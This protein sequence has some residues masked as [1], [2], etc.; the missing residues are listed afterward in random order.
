VAA[1]V[2]LSWFLAVPWAGASIDPGEP[3]DN[4]VDLILDWNTHALTLS[5][6][7]A[8]ING[9]VIRSTAGIFTGALANNLGF[10]TEDTDTRISG[11]MGF[12]LTGE[13]LLGPV[14]G[15]EWHN[16]AVDPYE[17]LTLTYTSPGMP[18][19]FLGNLIVVPIPEP[20]TAVMLLGGLVGLSLSR[21][22]RPRERS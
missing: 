18:G 17:D 8:T 10:F 19:T 4:V 13:H 7:A 2:S 11:N 22:R 16:P 5:T 21:Y 14:I 12:T 3:G 15:L 1:V 9:Y 6:D 20:S